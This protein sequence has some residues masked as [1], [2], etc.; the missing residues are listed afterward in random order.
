MDGLK[1]KNARQR[2]ECL[3]QLGY[4]IESVGTTVCQPSAGVALK[5]IAK[6][7]SDRDNSVRS[8]ALNCIVAAYFLDGEKVLKT[9]GQI[10]D[11]DMSLLEE[12]IKRAAKN[13]PVASIKPMPPAAS[14]PGPVRAGGGRAATPDEP[15]DEPEEEEVEEEAPHPQ[16]VEAV[17]QSDENLNSSGDYESPCFRPVQVNTDIHDDMDLNT[18]PPRSQPQPVTGPYRL[19]PDFLAS[20]EVPV[21]I[22]R[23]NIKEVDLSFL[24]EPVPQISRPP[25]LSATSPLSK[26]AHP[27]TI[28]WQIQQMGNPNLEAALNAMA[29]IETVLLSE[30]RNNL[31]DHVDKFVT[32]LVNQ[33][34][35]LNNSNHPDIVSCYRLNFALLMKL[36]NYP[37]LSC[38]VSEGVIKDVIHQLISLL[39]EK[40]LEMYDTTEMFVKVVNCLVLRI[41]E[42]SEHTA[43]TCA[44]LKLLYETVNNDS[45]LPLYQELVMK[46]IWRVLKSIPE[47]DEVEELDYDRILPDVHTFLKDYPSH[48]WKK[49]R[50]DTPLRTVKTVLHTLVKLKGYD[51]LPHVKN[52]KGI[53]PESEMFTYCNKLLRTLKVVDN[54]AGDCQEKKENCK[55]K[56]MPK[57]FRDQ[58]SDIFIKIGS[59]TETKEGLRMLYDFKQQHPDADIQPFLEKSTKFFQDYIQR[60]LQAIEMEQRHGHADN[61]T[62]KDPVTK[63]T[64]NSSRGLD[65]VAVAEVEVGDDNPDLQRL[66]SY[67]QRLR[68]LRAK[69]NLEPNAAQ[70]AAS[71]GGG[72][73]TAADR[74]DGDDV[75]LPSR[76][77]VFDTITNQSPE[78]KSADSKSV[79]ALRQRF[80]KIKQGA[81][82]DTSS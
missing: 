63:V 81:G 23:P 55:P 3:D 2:S 48:W 52:V 4:L 59:K 1:S 53:T 26:L 44:L 65:E 49:Q 69:A 21:N 64:Q 33:L 8:G 20:I 6:H 10:S 5:E 50:S 16:Q 51:L 13:R 39:T 45:L 9:V 36:Y 46:C 74:D 7:I 62:E 18:S 30:K 17:P 32:Q 82:L 38:K 66:N 28:E 76:K 58:L 25:K 31:Q 42:R 19:D 72:A 40:K 80:Q 54:A 67:M 78:K 68:V 47:W 27:S 73:L 60:G 15:L 57:S 14:R 12:R 70:H 24:R 56:R 43:S 11:K 35:F 29:Q 79:E 75:L 77:P 37:E 41:L 34:I 71:E 22:Q 61:Q